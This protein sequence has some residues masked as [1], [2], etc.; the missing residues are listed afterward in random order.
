MFKTTVK[1]EKKKMYPSFPGKII[2]KA[3]G[4]V[5]SPPGLQQIKGIAWEMTVDN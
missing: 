5:S 1:G 2:A 3:E 4:S